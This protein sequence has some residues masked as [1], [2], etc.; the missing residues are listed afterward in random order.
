VKYFLTGHGGWLPGDGFFGL[1]SGTTVTFYTENAKLMLASDVYKIVEGTYTQPPAQ[2]IK[3]QMSCQNMTLYPDDD[4][5]IQPTLSALA[6]NA[7]GD[8]CDVI[9]VTQPMK[10]RQIVDAFPGGDF[11]WACCR[12]LS[13]KPA[14]NNLARD[15]GVNAAQTDGKFINFDKN[16]WA[17]SGGAYAVKWPI[18]YGR[19]IAF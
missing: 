17:L 13:L 10:L 16:T 15:A 18:R 19:L 14:G 12:D 6:K 5:E 7:E 4:S 3:Q 11:V 2:V 9:R 8:K 1:P